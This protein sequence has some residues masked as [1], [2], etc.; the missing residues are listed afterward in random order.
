MRLFKGVTRELINN[1]NREIYSYRI[2][3]IDALVFLTYRCTSR[4]KTCN[5]WKRNADREAELGWEGWKSVL[6]RLR[7]YGIRSVEI[8]GGDALLRKDVIFNMIRF[9]SD[10][11][12][13]TY[14]PTNS[15]LMDRV[16][17]EGLVEAGL[18]TIYFSLD[19]IDTESDRVRGV[20]GTFSKVK[21]A[22]EHL[23]EARGEREYPKIIICSTLSNM[24]FESLEDIIGFLKDYPVDAVYPRLVTEFSRRNIDAS[25]IKGIAP[26]PYF[27]SSEGR[28]HLF[29]PEQTRRFREIINRLKSGNGSGPYINFQGI[30]F[31]PDEAFTSG[32]YGI[33]RCLVCSTLVTINPNGDVTPC[34]FYPAYIIGN[35]LTADGLDRIWGSSTH[36]EFIQQQR[37]AEIK[38]CSG[39]IMPTFYPTLRERLR[40]YLK[41][42][43]DKVSVLPRRNRRPSTQTR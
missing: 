39:C 28:S 40:Y 24:N 35:L 32:E 34:P 3:A 31:A 17:A 36:T 41:R 10:H 30:D 20:S 6:E 26:D 15:I 27:V 2:R 23:V 13:K 37:R 8:F 7:D 33:R 29:S 16:T 5:I 19:A 11:G 42:L 25:V 38:L 14:F 21:R 18:D 12:I 4:C 9:C 1:F 22:I 43:K